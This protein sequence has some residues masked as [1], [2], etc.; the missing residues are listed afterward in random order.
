M[1]AVRETGAGAGAGGGGAPELG[2]LMHAAFR[3]LRRRWSDQL[4]PLDL[5]PHQ[6]RALFAVE[7][8]DGGAGVR[9]KDLAERLRIAPRSA[10]EVVDQLAE[11]GLVE[12]LPDPADRR[13]TRI[14]LT[15]AGTGLRRQVTE[16]RRAES[17]DFFAALDTEDQTELARLLQLL[18]ERTTP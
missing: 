7:R 16:V 2:E 5:T 4:A 15:Q 8:G 14:V 13:A 6:S 9:L 17:G 3:Q 12:R 18:T 10:T 1:D 11:K